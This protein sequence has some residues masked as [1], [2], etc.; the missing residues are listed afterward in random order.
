MSLYANVMNIFSDVSL[1]GSYFF[2]F[3]FW[4]YW[5]FDSSFVLAIQT[6][7][8]LRHNSGPFCPSYFG[9]GGLMNYLPGWP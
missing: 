3:I 8:H 6:L 2:I 1:V 5:G 7:Y 9:N 4:W